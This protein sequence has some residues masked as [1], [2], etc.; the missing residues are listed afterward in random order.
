MSKYSVKVDEE[1]IWNDDPVSLFLDKSSGKFSATVRGVRVEADTLPD[2]RESVK[3]TAKRLRRGENVKWQSIIFMQR[4][5]DE[6]WT[7]R[8]QAE[9]EGRKR[10]G[11]FGFTFSRAEYSPLDKE[12]ILLRPFL[13]EGLADMDTRDD[14]I[15]GQLSVRRQMDLE[16]ARKQRLADREHGRDVHELYIGHGSQRRERLGSF[17]EYTSERWDALLL[18]E[19]MV[20]SAKL[21]LDDI[22][23]PKRGAKMLDKAVAAMAAGG[24]LALLPAPARRTPDPADPRSY[25][26]AK[27]RFRERYEVHGSRGGTR[28]VFEPD[29]ELEVIKEWH[30]S[31]TV[32]ALTKGRRGRAKEA[33]A[34]LALFVVVGG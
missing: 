14:E 8:E 22:T 20:A 33:R 28:E 31:L 26:G 7:E 34:Q 29:E 17:I 21:K 18:L 2:L 4:Y 12:H 10:G 15:P 32:R 23:D 24:G 27:V 19:R 1:S 9:Q 16:K 30:G 11:A 25:I 13:V 6:H 5:G 3:E